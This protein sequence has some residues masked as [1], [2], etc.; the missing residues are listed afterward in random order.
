MKIGILGL[1]RSGKSTIFAA[2]TGQQPSEVLHPGK[3]RSNMAVVRV[4]DKRLDLVADMIKP[5]KVVHASVEYVDVAGVEKTE[6][7]KRKGIPE[8]QIPELSMTEALMA[9]IRA[10]DD[11][12]GIP[13]DV[14]GDLATINLELIL[15]DLSRIENRLPALEKSIHK[16]GGKEQDKAKQEMEVLSRLRS[17]LEEEIPVRDV[18]L[19]EEEKKIVKGF[20]FLSEKPILVLLNIDEKDLGRTR[21]ELLYKYNLPPEKEGFHYGIMCAEI[22]AE[23]A[24]LSEEDKRDFLSSYSISEP[25]ASLIIKLCYDLLGYISFFTAGEREVH[26][27]TVKEGACAKEGAGKIHTDLEKGFIRAEVIRW[28]QLLEDGGFTAARKNGHLRT[29]GKDYIVKDGD[30]MHIL[31]N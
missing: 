1:A 26:A 9:V 21:E 28:D 4:P 30:I 3:S 29:E 25:S 15:T 8:E 27:W 20:S 2:L 12:S 24:I 11:G 7:V 14:P 22:E 5:A 18:D 13:A 6:A 16:L 10:F 23:I 19:S 31:H 17:C